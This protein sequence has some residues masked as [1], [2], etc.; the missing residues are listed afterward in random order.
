MVVDIGLGLGFDLVDGRVPED[1]A[2]YAERQKNL[3]QVETELDAFIRSGGDG[4]LTNIFK[5]FL[6]LA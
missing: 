1:T 4:S 6:G 2:D 3:L 5:M